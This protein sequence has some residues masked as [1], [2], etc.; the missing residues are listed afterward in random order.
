MRFIGSMLDDTP[1]KWFPPMRTRRTPLTQ[2]QKERRKQRRKKRFWIDVFFTSAMIL[3][4]IGYLYLR[5]RS[6][7]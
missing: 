3:V 7:Q 2:E 5:H 6:G 1:A 4:G